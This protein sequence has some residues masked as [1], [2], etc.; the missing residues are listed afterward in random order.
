[1]LHTRHAEDAFPRS[2]PPDIISGPTV[3]IIGGSIVDVGRDYHKHGDVFNN[4][5]IS[6][7]HSLPG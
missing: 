6:I 3:N 4:Q 7:H 1:M 5:R 2:L